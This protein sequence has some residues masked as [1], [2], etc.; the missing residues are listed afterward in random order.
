MAVT[1]NLTLGQKQDDN[2]IIVTVA[3]TNKLYERVRQAISFSDFIIKEDSGRD[4]L[5]TA[6]ERI[7]RTYESC[8]T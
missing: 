5:R 8:A 1:P 7:G 6:A 2:L 4:T 3:D